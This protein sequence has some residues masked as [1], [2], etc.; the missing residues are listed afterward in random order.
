MEAN[1]LMSQL[2]ADIS[3]ADYRHLLARMYGYYQPLESALFVWPEWQQPAAA[4]FDLARRHK[5][6]L[7]TADLR[8]LGLS[9]S[10]LHALPRCT[11]LPDLTSFAHALGCMY[12]L[13]GATLGGQGIS[14]HL[15]QQLGLTPDSGTA[16]FASYRADVGRMWKAFVALLND[17][18]A[19]PQQHEAMLSAACQTFATLDSWLTAAHRNPLTL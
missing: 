1:P 11:N 12:V 4:G 10:D 6:P 8:T 5:L 16:F 15:R 14:R 13:E 7:L 18:P 2:Q 3:A 19:T 17:Y 9:S